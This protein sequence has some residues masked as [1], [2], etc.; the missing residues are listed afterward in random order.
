MPLTMWAPRYSTSLPP[1]RVVTEPEYMEVEGGSGVTSRS[2]GS[3]LRGKFITTTM[4]MIA[5]ARALIA[6]MNRARCF[7]LGGSLVMSFCGV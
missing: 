7:L 2:P 6:P 3:A 4:A 1:T 5:R